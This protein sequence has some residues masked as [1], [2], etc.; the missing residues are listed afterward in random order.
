M[1]EGALYYTFTVNSMIRGYHIFKDIWENPPLEKN[2]VASKKL[3]IQK[4]R[5]PLL[6]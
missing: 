5:W 6:S 1:A 2:S 4:I 3:E